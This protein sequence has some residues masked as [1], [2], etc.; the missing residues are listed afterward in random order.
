METTNIPWLTL[1]VAQ[2]ITNLIRLKKGRTVLLVDTA[3]LQETC[4]WQVDN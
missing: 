3:L 2:D 4:L 1:W